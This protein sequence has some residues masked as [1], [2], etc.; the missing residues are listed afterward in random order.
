M[1]SAINPDVPK[2]QARLILFA[3]WVTTVLVSILAHRQMPLAPHSSHDAFL[4]I[5]QLQHLL[6]GA[7]PDDARF[8]MFSPTWFSPHAIATGELGWSGF[9]A[10]VFG[11]VQSHTWI[12]V[13]HPMALMAVLAHATGAGVVV[14]VLVQ[15]FYLG[16]LL[17][18]LFGIGARCCSRKAGLLAAALAAGSPALIGS[19]RYI[20]PHLAVAAVSTLL[21]C[22]LMHTEGLRRIGICV[23]ASV[24]MWTLS[25]SGE[26]SGEVVI[27]GL[28]VVGPGVWA[29]AKSDRSLQPGRW[30]IGLLA[31][32]MPFILL[33]DL[34]WMVGAM[35]RV[36]RA[37]ADPP[38]QSDVAAKGGALGHPVTWMGAYIV[39]LFTDYLR[40]LLAVV[41]AIGLLATR[42]AQVKHKWAVLLWLGVPWL[43][44][45]WMQRKASWYGLGLIPP[46]ILCAAIGLAQDKRRWPW[47]VGVLVALIQ[48]A[49]FNL[50]PLLLV[51]P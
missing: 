5:P 42:S 8:G 27:A 14:A 1:N 11:N 29:I 19:V 24:T 35:E 3:I 51:V 47:R 48:L 15:C 4:L 33:A 21:V 46:V 40:P 39:L 30:L 12:D 26:G 43:A 31:L 34:P 7:V 44:L 50:V 9:W 38:V 20:E 45:S 6:S 18:G 17:V 22:L 10:R 32:V 25:R 41:V 2:R 36:T 16:L 23:L 13:P 37:F 28:L 49:L